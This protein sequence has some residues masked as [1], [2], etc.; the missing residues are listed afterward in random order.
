MPQQQIKVGD[1]VRFL[2]AVGGG[3]VSAFQGKDIVIVLEE[4][5]FETPVL[6]RDVVVVEETNEYNFPVANAS[7]NKEVAVDTEAEA[8]PSAPKHD[9]SDYTFDEKD[10]T[11][12]GE[13]LNLFLGFVPV[14]PKKLQVCDTD[15]YLVNDSNYYLDFTLVTGEEKAVVKAHGT[16][17]PQTKLF[18]ESIKKTDLNEWEWVRFQALP[19][20]RRDG[21]TIKRAVDVA[22]K[23]NQTK[24][25][26][27]HAF[28]ENDYFD[29]DALL[30][31][32]LINDEPDLTP[33]YECLES[34]P[35]A[36]QQA[37]KEKERKPQ[38]TVSKSS[39]PN[40][41]VEVDLHINELI[42]NTRGLTNTEM[43]EYQLKAFRETMDKHIKQKG[44]RIVFIHGNG[45]GVLRKAIED[46]LRRNYPTC[47]FYPAPFQKYG[48]GAK[49]VIVG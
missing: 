42:D 1:K 37:V 47:K 18:L 10:E 30:S 44:Q 20:K 5:G 24:F 22:L 41:V 14:D 19:Y 29:E 46:D 11:P 34:Q 48:H 45:E 8:R 13:K 40:E 23:L 31:T 25:F 16:I 33:R 21:Y 49:L 9:N 32:L 15:V 38:R 43:L 36:F 26:K 6:R 39:K 3:K 27:L 4:D 12:E 7:K 2:N 35:K 17:E 28:K